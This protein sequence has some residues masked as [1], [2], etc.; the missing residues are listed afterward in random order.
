V[1]A[2]FSAQNQGDLPRAEALYLQALRLQPEQPDALQLL[3]GLARRQGDVAGAETLLRRSL[4]Q[5]AE[6]PHV[7]NSL[8]NLLEAT[9][10][11]D[12]ALAAFA[13]AAVQA[14]AF[15]DAHYNRARVLHQQGRLPQ[16]AASLNQALVR[17]PEPS[18]GMLQLH[19]QIEGDS[20]HLDSA[21]RTLERALQR[22]P[23]RPALWHNR[24]VLLQ[25]R[26]RYA[27][28]LQAHE[29][30][31]A[32]GLD[33]ADAH[34]NRGNTLQSLG[35]L[36]EAA[37]AYRQ[38][39]AQDGG[40]ALALYDLARLRWSLGEADFDAELRHAIAGPQATPLLPGIHAHLLWR[41]E[42][43][44]DAAQAY[45]LALQATPAAAG[46]HDGL[47]RCL[48]R[49]GQAS[50]GLQAHQQAVALAPDDAE[51]RGNHAAS[52]LM[53][54][55]FDA[56]LAEAEAACSLAPQHQHAQA[57]RALAC[58]VLGDPRTSALNDTER[59][60]RVF[61]L[62]PPPGFSDM[63]AFNAALAR[64]LAPLHA[65]DRQA[66]I[67]Q[68]LRGGT[69][70]R[71]DIFE[72]GHALVDALKA[73]IAE[74]VTAYIQA[75]PADRAHPVLGRRGADWRFSD[76]WSSRLSR[77]GFHTDHV[78]PHGWVSSAY[79]V[80]VPAGVAQAQSH[81]QRESERHEG[82]LQFGRPDLPLPG[83]AADSLVQRRVQPRPGRLVLFPSMM[84]HGTLPFSDD[85][86]RLTLAFDVLP[87]SAA[88]APA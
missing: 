60:V 50:A 82:W 59:L 64:E 88:A 76:S 29:R 71:G 16:A 21:L 66:P 47:G 79:Y 30:A 36:D 34:Y 51:L 81:R 24:A 37:A 65:A 58:R 46:L 55:R 3:G 44:A 33:A 54:G 8:G 41:A 80:A 49:L 57:L 23:E 77:L 69:Q 87:S 9:G 35:R 4:Q 53:A 67:D 2:G 52:L 17:A 20:G 68:T 13:R 28:A 75:L 86:E 11:P 61:D 7:W 40:H 74:A 12:E 5:R 85:A 31:A 10:R 39:L 63:G 84:W 72:Q 62:P 22:A 27:E 25:R 83:I 38:A 15:V 56:A 43:Y 70:T 73:R 6:Q 18:I 42:R 14:P 48:L 19:A 26:H 78:H 45:R 1:Q 32:L